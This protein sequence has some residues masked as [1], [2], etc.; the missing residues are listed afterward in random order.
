MALPFTY[1]RKVTAYQDGST[2]PDAGGTAPSISTGQTDFPVLVYIDSNA[3]NDAADT[4]VNGYLDDFFDGTNNPGGKRVKFYPSEADLEADT[5]A[6]EYE[7]HSFDTGAETAEYWVERTTGSSSTEIWIGFGEGASGWAASDQ[8]NK[9]GTWNAAYKTVHHMDD[10]PDTSTVQDS[11]S[12]NFDGSKTAAANPAEAVGQIGQG[13]DFITDD[14]ISFGDVEAA[15]NLTL[16]GW[17]KLDSGTGVCSLWDKMNNPT[18]NAGFLVRLSSGTLQVFSD[19][20]TAQLA[21]A[22]FMSGADDGVWRHVAIVFDNAGTPTLRAYKDGVVNVTTATYTTL[23][24]NARTMYVGARTIGS[25]EDFLDGVV[26]EMRVSSVARSAD[27]IKSTY[28]STVSTNYPGDNWLVWSAAEA[29]AAATTFPVPG[30][31]WTE[32][33]N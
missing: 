2:T 22:N 17:F 6:L 20:G 30:L 14:L 1:K 7:P 31:V 3:W 32:A 13:Q 28:Y 5:N 15:D 23:S 19:T 18:Y 9:T 24:L 16:E 11:T 33:L 27:W 26:D 4:A 21:I 10:D 29:V 25:E 8:D 12:N